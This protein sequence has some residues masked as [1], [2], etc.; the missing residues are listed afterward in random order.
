[1]SRKEGKGKVSRE[2][3]R[4]SHTDVFRD[5][6]R[7]ARSQQAQSVIGRPR[8]TIQCWQISKAQSGTQVGTR[9][10]DLASGT[11]DSV[12]QGL[13]CPNLAMS[14]PDSG[15]SSLKH[16]CLLTLLNMCLSLDCYRVNKPPAG[17]FTVTDA[18]LASAGIHV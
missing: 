5:S 10:I 2:S 13:L 6:V 11:S 3:C 14:L 18:A 17:A 15:E 1:M 12:A 7:R 4:G 9:S 8:K 16:L